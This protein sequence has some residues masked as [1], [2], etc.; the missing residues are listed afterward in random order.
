MRKM[1]KF[2]GKRVASIGNTRK[3]VEK[4][5]EKNHFIQ[6]YILCAMKKKKEVDQKYSSQNA[7]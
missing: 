7:M 4:S 5:R 1:R 3:L 2:C 6:I